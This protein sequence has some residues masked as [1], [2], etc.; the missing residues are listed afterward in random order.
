MDDADLRHAMDTNE[1]IN[2][3]HLPAG[4][5]EI[6]TKKSISNVPLSSQISDESKPVTKI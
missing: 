6:V 4:P 1:K 3:A 2:N 5:V